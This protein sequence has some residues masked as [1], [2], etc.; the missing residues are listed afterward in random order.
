MLDTIADGLSGLGNE[1]LAQQGVGGG[2]LR[3]RGEFR[4]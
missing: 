4:L 3:L 1:S 2:A